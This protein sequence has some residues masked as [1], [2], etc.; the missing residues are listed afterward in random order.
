MFFTFWGLNVLKKSQKVNVKK[1][2]MEKMFDIMLPDHAGKLPLSKMNMG[3]MGAKM[4]KGIMEK[5]NVDSLEAMIENAIKLGVNMVA[6]SMSMDLMD[7]KKEEL[8]DGVTIA[9]VA[10]YLSDTEKSGLNL[11]I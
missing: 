1:E 7:I 8:I 9:G 11:F 10:S 2:G 3:G 5:N 4:I 6:C